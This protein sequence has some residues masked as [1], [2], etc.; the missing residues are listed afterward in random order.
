[1]NFLVD[2]HLPRGICTILNYSGHDAI[3]TNTLPAQNATKD[4]VI[5]E[6]SVREQ[7]VVISKD[8]DF[9]HSHLLYGKPWKLVL[10]RTGNTRARDLNQLFQCHLLTIIASLESNS[11][12]ELYR[13]GVRIVT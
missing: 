3:H 9:Y 4:S 13:E 2:A 11:L 5:N 1:M 7:R 12:I 10:V 8:T 6:I